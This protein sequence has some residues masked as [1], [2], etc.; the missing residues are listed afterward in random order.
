MQKSA[1]KPSLRR[2]PA[3][4]RIAFLAAPLPAAGY[5]V[6]T[7]LGGAVPTALAWS[8][9]GL[10]D[11]IARG[12]GSDGI[13][14][15]AFLLALL[16]VASAL[17][18]R[19][20]RHCQAMTQRATRLWM[21]DRLFRALNEVR[22]I[23]W[24]EDPVSMDRVQLALNASTTAPEV[25]LAGCLSALQGALIAVGLLGSLW[26]ISPV[27][28]LLLTVAA[29]PVLAGQLLL[30]REQTRLEEDTVQAS[31]RE[32]FYRM[33]I[34]GLDAVKEVRIFGLGDFFRE[35]MNRET[36]SIHLAQQRVD[37]RQLL[38]QAVL[39][40]LSAVVVGGCVVWS[41]AEAADGR[42]GI[43]DLS[44]FIAAAA[45]VQGAVLQTA[46]GI[47]DGYKSLLAFESYRAV[48]GV[49]AAGAAKATGPVGEPVRLDGDIEVRDLWFRYSDE[50]DW[51]LRGVDLTIPAGRSLALVGVNGAGKSTLVKLLCGLYEPTRGSIS[52]GGR[53]IRTVPAGDHQLGVGAIFQDYMSYDLSAAENIGLGDLG[54]LEDRA[55]IRAAAGRAGADGFLESLPDGY[56]TLLSRIFFAGDAAGG[57]SR[58]THLSG[59]QWQRLAVARGLMKRRSHLVILDEPSSG[60]DAEAEA[61]L[62][63]AL[64][65]DAAGTTRLL[66]SH[67]LGAVKAADAI[68][69]LEQGR[70]GALGDH[71]ALMA[72]GGTYHRLFTVQAAGYA[73]AAV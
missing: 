9:K 3:I 51:V 53:D 35:R 65:D 70:I 4:L 15:Q 49:R 60:L 31:R 18:P 64:L 1:R 17:A 54:R 6:L 22:D 24:F 73:D 23:S 12:A 16:G 27:V 67:R 61:A 34:T 68:A 7:V 55:A 19:L 43:G 20:A 5:L 50:G 14:R 32:V 71:R 46:T 57:R 2:L 33:L 48:T 36:R 39:A 25:L 11:K 30:S 66:I 69:V 63:E 38:R 45:G 21:R 59:G 10:L 56:D 8:T 58:G 26:V 37:T 47:G 44:V 13:V 40:V 42:L 41:A 62:H 29:L 28:F 52:V 72:A